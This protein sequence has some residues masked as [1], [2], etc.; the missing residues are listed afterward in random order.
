MFSEC[1]YGTVVL[2]IAFEANGPG[3]EYKFGPRFEPGRE[4]FF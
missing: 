1:R 4:L 2:A 3:K